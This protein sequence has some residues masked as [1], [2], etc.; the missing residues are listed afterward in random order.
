MAKVLL[1]NLIL[2]PVQE[3]WLVPD[4]KEYP[5]GHSPKGRERRKERKISNLF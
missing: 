4:E 2:L 1:I 5:D 3:K